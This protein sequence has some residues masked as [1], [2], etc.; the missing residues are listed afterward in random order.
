MTFWNYIGEFFL[1]RWLFDKFRKPTTAPDTHAE[2]AGAS[3]DRNS[4]YLNSNLYDVIAPDDAVTD[5][6]DNLIDDSGNSEDLDDPDIFMRDN[7]GF[8]R[9]Y[10]HYGDYD[11][12]YNSIGRHSTRNEWTSRSNSQPYDDFHDEQDD[13][14]MMDDDF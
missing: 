5:I 10:Q 2:V 1:F 3:I 13:F 12:D 11:I 9:S 6:S 4:E 8:N 14:D 7:K